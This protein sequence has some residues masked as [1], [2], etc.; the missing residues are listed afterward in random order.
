M[1]KNGNLV[2][3][4]QKIRK[5]REDKKYSQEE[6]AAIA[7][8]DRTYYGAIERGERNVSAIN[9]IRIAKHLKVEV[10]ELFPKIRSLD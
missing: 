3:M 5:I 10:G 7:E 6:F 8:F 4:G 9:L 1:R 2:A